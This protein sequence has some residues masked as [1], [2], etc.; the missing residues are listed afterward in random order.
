[1]LVRHISVIHL[2]EETL[3]EIAMSQVIFILQISHRCETHE[4][5][6][7]PHLCMHI[8]GSGGRFLAGGFGSCG[9]YD[10]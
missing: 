3:L 8:D 2:I 4:L 10:Q 9:N 1:M 7:F 5:E 6:H